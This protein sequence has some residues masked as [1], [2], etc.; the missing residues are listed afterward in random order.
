VQ[1]HRASRTDHTSVSYFDGDITAFFLKSTYI[2]E[3]IER[4]LY[5]VGRKRELPYLEKNQ[6]GSYWIVKLNQIDSY[7]ILE[8][9]PKKKGIKISSNDEFNFSL[10]H[11]KNQLL[12]SLLKTERKER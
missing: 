2:H 11:W 4:R 7:L 8:Y 3:R 5:N 10:T 1:H 9:V 12:K 6:E